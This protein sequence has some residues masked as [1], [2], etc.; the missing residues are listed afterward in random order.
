LVSGCGCVGS[1][2]GLLLA[3]VVYSASAGISTD[4]VYNRVYKTAYVYGAP[5]LGAP[6]GLGSGIEAS[7]L[8]PLEPR[9]AG[10]TGGGRT[11]PQSL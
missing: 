5:F 1:A 2:L 9:P 8:S 10:L 4:R 11:L 6:S 7:P 3:A